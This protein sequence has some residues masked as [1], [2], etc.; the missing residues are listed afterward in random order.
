MLRL[1]SPAIAITVLLSGC[2]NDSK[3]PSTGLTIEV[4]TAKPAEFDRVVG[5]GPNLADRIIKA[6]SIKSFGGCN[7]LITRVSGMG[8]LSAKK[9]SESGLRVNGESC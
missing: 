2:A 1:L 9:F 8:P 3:V 4:N 6:R 7:D 5:L